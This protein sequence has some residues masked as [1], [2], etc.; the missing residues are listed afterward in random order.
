M[1]IG[2]SNYIKEDSFDAV[3]NTS[4]KSKNQLDNSISKQKIDKSIGNKYSSGDKNFSWHFNTLEGIKALN[5]LDAIFF[6]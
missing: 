3:N 6:Y 1:G 4:I 2:S 5:E